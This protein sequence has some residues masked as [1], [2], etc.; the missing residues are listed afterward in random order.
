[1]SDA[2]DGFVQINQAVNPVV[3]ATEAL[4]N[5]IKKTID[6]TK[7]LGKEIAADA[8]S[9]Q[10]V[11]DLRAKA[12]KAERDL[13]VGRAKADRDR[14]ALLEKSVDKE[15]FTVQQRIEFLKQAAAVE[16][17]I[18]KQEIEAARLRAEAK[19]LENTLSK[20]TKEDMVEEEELK[21]RLIN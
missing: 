5:G 7:E 8:Q 21:A 18:T 3:I 14:A 16:E 10:R 12:D 20:S 19:T 17:N 11:A 4:A 2:K 1:M 15:N 13:I 9:A 6:A